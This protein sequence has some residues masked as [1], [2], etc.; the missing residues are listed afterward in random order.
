MHLSVYLLLYDWA[1]SF[2]DVLRCLRR[3]IGERGGLG[4]PWVWE[5]LCAGVRGTGGRARLARR[6]EG[7]R[8]IGY[9]LL[10]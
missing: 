10:L 7:P 3:R 1:W 2:L 5:K 8:E 6:Q 4:T 9:I